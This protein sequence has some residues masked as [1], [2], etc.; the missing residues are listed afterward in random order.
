MTEDSD[1]QPKGRPLT[2]RKV[3]VMLLGFFG[4]MAAVNFYM[5]REAIATHPGLDHKNPYDAG[6]AYNKEI[7]AARAQDALGWSV[8]LTRA[9]NGAATEVTASVKDKAGQPVTGLEAALHFDHPSSS[10]LDV[11][12]AAPA[13]AAGVYAGAADLPPGHWQVEIEFKRAGEIVFRS[14][15]T[16]NV[17]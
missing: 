14:K 9:K 12:V 11:D 13:K 2:G 6:V 4:V 1:Y 16:L 17:E 7:A 8:G 3:L 10:R 15:N 5:A